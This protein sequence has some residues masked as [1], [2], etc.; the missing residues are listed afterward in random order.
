MLSVVSNHQV[1]GHRYALARRRTSSS[2][3][4]LKRGT[5]GPNSAIIIRMKRAHLWQEAALTFFSC[6]AG[7]VRRVVD[8]CQWYKVALLACRARFALECDL[9]PVF[10]TIR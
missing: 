1:V 8:D 10:L 9:V 5:I 3:F 2:S 7:L 4:H 6:N